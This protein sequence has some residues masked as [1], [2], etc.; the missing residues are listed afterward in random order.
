MDST[1]DSVR[2]K[3]SADDDVQ[4]ISRSSRDTPQDEAETLPSSEDAGGMERHRN[5]MLASLL[6]DYY[7]SRALEFLNATNPDQRYT[8][9]SQ[10]V[11]AVT[12]QL[13]GQA[14]QVL[15]SSGLIPSRATSDGA[16]GIRRQYLSG[17]EGLVAGSQTSNILDSIGEL[18]AQT[19]QLNL[20]A[21]PTN[22]LQLSLHQPP[23]PS[24]H[25]HYRSTFREDRLLG[26]GGF[27]KVY[28]CYNLLDQKTYAV[29][30]IILPPKLVKSVSEGS[31]D[32]LQHVLREVKAMA[33]LD[34]PNIVR[35]HATWFEKPQQLREALSGLESSMSQIRR[36]PQR[37][38]LDSHA[39][40]R[41]MEQGSSISGGI[42]FEEDTPSH[43]S[44]ITGLDGQNPV[45]RGWS[46]DDGSDSGVPETTS[47]SES[48]IF[49]G[50][51]TDSDDSAPRHTT[52]EAHVCALFIQ[53]SMYPMTLAQFLSPPS[54]SAAGLRHCFH[55]APTLRLMLSIHDGLQYVHSKGLIH[56][57][58]KPGNIFLS[59]PSTTF[60]GGSCDV[61]CRLCTESNQE[62]P[63]GPTWLNPRIGDFGLV[64][65]VAQGEVPATPQ[66]SPDPKNDAGTAYYQPPR[67]SEKK[68]EKI[69]IFALGVVL[70]E[71]MCRCNTA[72]ERVDM[73]KGLQRGQLPPTLRGNMRD[74]GHDSETA[75]RV[76]ELMSSMLDEDPEKRW[77]A[78]RVRESLLDLLGRCRG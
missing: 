17:L 19:S 1:N 65:Q 7:R 23:P 57:D 51:E 78:E 35:Y 16:R 44:A 73:L 62:T 4:S 9:Q 15:S 8:R 34:H 75:D 38:L 36:R 48:D 22:D 61:S 74:E 53:M 5:M 71:M 55:L 72:M 42:V 13:F 40:T 58:I 50:G 24:S 29:K 27:G 70:V 14:S 2:S 39:F 49:A 60:E 41:D 28:Q 56:R 68:D 52:R 59:S 31:H 67:K 3:A 20:A 46:E 37:L 69:D 10:E 45:D 63:S 26:K 43:P 66:N 76:L 6:E 32:D 77:S 12:S 25:S 64:H 11:E 33:M 18:V 54:S 47:A 21:H 30:K